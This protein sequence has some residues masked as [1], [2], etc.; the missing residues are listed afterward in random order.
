VNRA[1][2][3]NDTPLGTPIRMSPV[4]DT[5]VVKED[6][7]KGQP[8]VGTSRKRKPESETTESKVRCYKLTGLRILIVTRIHPNQ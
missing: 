3:A 2:G 6:A 5:P 1:T 7:Q 8:A 4:N